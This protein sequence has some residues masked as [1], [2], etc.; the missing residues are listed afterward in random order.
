VPRDL[1][2]RWHD[3]PFP[4]RRVAVAGPFDLAPTSIQA[5]AMPRKPGL[6]IGPHPF[7]QRAC[8]V[9]WG[10]MDRL[11]GEFG[12]LGVELGGLGTEF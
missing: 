5:A 6:R 7:T 9:V 4:P 3:L 1:P 11:A 10:W 12:P 8:Q 2:L